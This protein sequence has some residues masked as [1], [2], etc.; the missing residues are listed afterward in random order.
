M[1][2]REGD[3][4]VV[5]NQGLGD[6]I[7]HN[8]MVRYISKIYEGNIYH[9]V[10]GAMGAKHGTNPYLEMMKW[11]YRDN[12]RIKIVP[13]D[14]PKDKKTGR[15]ISGGEKDKWLNTCIKA[16]LIWTD[17]DRTGFANFEKRLTDPSK[18]ISG[19]VEPTKFTAISATHQG[20]SKRYRPLRLAKAFY[21]TAGIPYQVK[22]DDFYFERDYEEEDRVY[23]KLNPHGDKYVFVHDDIPRGFLIDVNFRRKKSSHERK[24]YKIIRNDASENI[25]HMT[26][27]FENAEE[28]HCMSSS[29]ATLVDCIAASPL[30]E[31]NI[32][33][34]NKF[35]HWPVRKVVLNA[36]YL[37]A[38]NWK[39]LK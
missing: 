37:G 33:Q 26:K 8:G 27:V 34:I 18:G 28:I 15:N 31:T 3:A 13:L 16:F 24:G 39:V 19:I 10:C 7:E 20:W 17:S 12:P 23:K 2:K 30:L 14:T 6:L 25:F 38:D 11:M 29:I 22:F 5:P 21:H 9:F 32:N 36:G 4:L 1:K 35:L